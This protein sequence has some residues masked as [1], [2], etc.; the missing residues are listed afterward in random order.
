[1]DRLTNVEDYKADKVIYNKHLKQGYPQSIPTERFLRLAEYENTDLTPQEVEQ[2][3]AEN[4]EL[5]ERSDWQ[6]DV[7]ENMRSE[8]HNSNLE[9]QC[10]V[11]NLQAENAEYKQKLADGRMIELPCKVGDMVY[12]LQN[13]CT[14][15]ECINNIRGNCKN[16]LIGGKYAH[17]YCKQYAKLVPI[18]TIF[19]TEG[20]IVNNR[21]GIYLT[22]SQAK[23]ALKEMER[24]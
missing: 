7:F 4:A 1:M 9:L 17:E 18:Q 13:I 22:Y 21:N 8:L 14:N 12:T 5:K 2:L 23:Q 6:D 15:K 20:E 11:T 16:G 3:K 24:K 10:Q 19:Y